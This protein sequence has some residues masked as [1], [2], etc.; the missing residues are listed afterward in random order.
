MQNALRRRRKALEQRHLVF[1]A[2]ADNGF[3]APLASSESC[4]NIS[5]SQS[6][7]AEK[8]APDRPVFP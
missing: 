5:G 3:D 6:P 4:P 7:A 2:G 1:E 8:P